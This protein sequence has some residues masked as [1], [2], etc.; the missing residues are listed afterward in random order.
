[1]RSQQHCTVLNPTLSQDWTTDH[2]RAWRAHFV[3]QRQR[4]LG[5]EAAHPVGLARPEAA[6]LLHGLAD[7]VDAQL[8]HGPVDVRQQLAQRPN[9]LLAREALFRVGV[10]E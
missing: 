9:G 4:G 3:V 7:V 10:C 2:G 8:N 6:L 5:V 1:M